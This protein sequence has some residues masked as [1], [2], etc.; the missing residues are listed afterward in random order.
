M[1]TEL[2]TRHGP[3]ALPAFVPDAT[4][5]TI[6]SVPTHL[7]RGVGVEVLMCNALHLSERPGAE[8]VQALGGV[9]QFAGWDGPVMTDSGGFQV[10]SLARDRGGEGRVTNRGFT[11][12]GPGGRGKR[13]L[14][15]AKAVEHQLKLGT[16][17]AFCLDQCTHPDDAENVQEASVRRTLRW[18]QECRDTLDRRPPDARPRLFA[19]V[20]GG[21]SEVLRRR[22]VEGLLE[23]GFDGYGFGGVPVDG[24]GLVEQVALVA[25]LLP[26]DVPL[27]ALGV[28]RPN[29]VLAAWRAGWRTFDSVAP[30]REA[31]RGLLYEPTVEL[32]D[33]DA[34]RRAD[35]VSTYV[36][37]TDDRAWR[38]PR[39]ID[40]SCTCPLC[41]RYSRGYL[42][43]LFRLEDAAA[44]TLAT[45]HN[46]AF[47][48]RLVAAL[49]AIERD[50][51]RT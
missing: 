29:T 46:L 35:K 4:R 24:Q 42:A 38:D 32:D 49:R 36:D 48:N 5:G 31:R 51:G 43:H 8:A 13:L 25:E 22:C 17:I 6:R 20:Q 27:H 12:P 41:S 44:A 2:E 33:P 47:L 34:V 7:L 18:A 30:T 40:A 19:V 10:W 39:P 37:A 21:T 3:L 11:L 28:G 45:L 50:D 1:L 9:H 15:P 26:D 23:I 16:D 14:T